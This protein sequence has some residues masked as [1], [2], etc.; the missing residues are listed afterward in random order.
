MYH[1]LNSLH[2]LG[3]VVMAFSLTL[4]L[5]FVLSIIIDDGAA[6]YFVIP[7]AGAFVFGLLLTVMCFPF[8]GTL[9]RREG[10]LLVFLSW[11]C[12]GVIGSL[13]IYFAEQLIQED[14]GFAKAVFEGVSGL[15]TTGASVIN[16]VERLPISVN[17]WR[18]SLLWFGGMGILLL[19]VAILPLFN[20]GGREL[21]RSEMPGPLKEERLTPRIATTAKTL[22]SIYFVASVLCLI[23][24]RIAGLNWFDAWCHAASTMALGGF[25]SFNS[26]FK[27]MDNPAADLVAVVFMLFAG[28]NFAT[29]F[30]VLKNRDLRF[31]A[32]CPEALPFLKLVLGSGLIISAVLYFNGN[33]ETW[34]ES[35]RY[36]IFNTVSVATTTGFANADYLT[37]PF[38]I[39]VYMLA[40]GSFASSGGS[41]GGGI[42]LIRILLVFRRIRVE[43]LKLLHPHGIFPVRFK[44]TVVPTSVLLS[45]MTFI[46]LYMMTL[47]VVFAL[48]ALGGADPL[49]ASS[50]AVALVANIGPA[51]GSVG[52]MSNYA[53]FNDFQLWVSSAAMLVGRLELLTAFVIFTPHFWRR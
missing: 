9:R 23:S 15:T 11:V 25:S 48:L 3:M 4:I 41:T 36:G 50:A 38:V 49:T 39:P 35:L 19:A 32:Y 31:Y 51:I 34:F 7:A 30:K 33:Y 43:M 28:I 1:T 44:K 8:R 18:H 24:Y 2:K 13:P 27:S 45:V 40:L 29:H 10:I 14:F 26:S 20:V 17:I 16:E 6:Q 22:Y 52:P 47:M 46:A 21:M 5:P 53:N 42:K 37:W 12:L